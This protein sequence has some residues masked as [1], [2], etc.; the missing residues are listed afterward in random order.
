METKEIG[1]DRAGP[2]EE[3]PARMPGG[4]LVKTRVAADQTGGAYSL[5]EVEVVTC[6]C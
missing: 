1:A 4:R 6:G 5:F 3:Y 2:A